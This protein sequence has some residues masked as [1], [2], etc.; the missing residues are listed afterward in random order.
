MLTKKKPE[1]LLHKATGQAR[2]RINGRD[3]Y[4]GKYGSR[5]SRERYDEQVAEWFARSGDVSALRLTVDDLCILYQRFADQHYRKADVPTSEAYNIRVALRYVVAGFGEMRAR[6][7]GP[8]ALKAVRQS[9]IDAGCVRTSINRMM[10]RVRR[11]F[12][13]AVSEE[14][15]PVTVHQA[16]CTLPGLEVGRSTAIESAAVRP[17]PEAFV[18]AI[19]PYVSRQ[20]WAAIQLQILTG[21]RPGEVLSLRGCDLNTSGAVWEFI[22]ERHKTE[23]RGKERIIYL[24][25]RAQ[26]IVRQFLKPDLAAF[27]L[28]PADAKEEY[29][30]ARRAGRVT[31]LTPSQRRRRR[32]SNPEKKPGGRYSV[33]SYGRAIRNACLKADRAAHEEQPDVP[34]DQVIVP[35]W[36]AHQLRH[37]S[38]TALRRQ[39][40]IESARTVLGHA[41]TITTE[42]YALKDRE[43]AR[44]I[45]ATVG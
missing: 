19:Q 28:S 29:L 13:W 32:K 37:N 15:L 45:M 22:P 10:G 18:N 17:V 26:A 20:V 33:L 2:V 9:M 24:G 5:D 1:Y 44:E 31:P 16:L 6:D 27:L 3:I 43:K 4:L 7:F 42:V 23:H 40:G 38:A 39:F 36:H 25:P 34:A 14:M 41:T 21:A 11:L 12:K 30:A 35:N 8:R